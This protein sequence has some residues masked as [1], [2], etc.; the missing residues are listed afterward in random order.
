MYVNDKQ[1]S[2]VSAGMLGNNWAQNL[3]EHWTYY[4]KATYISNDGDN[5]L[6]R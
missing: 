4:Q 5:H 3:N 2:S 6:Y 1:L